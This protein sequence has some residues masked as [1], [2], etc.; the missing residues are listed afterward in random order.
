MYTGEGMDLKEG[1]KRYKE[2]GLV[3]G[4]NVYMKGRAKGKEEG[5]SVQGESN[6]GQA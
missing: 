4:R 3:R 5:E 2:R 6:V 1:K